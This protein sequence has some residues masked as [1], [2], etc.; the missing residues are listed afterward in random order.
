MNEITLN[1]IVYVPKAEIE[2][3]IK[4]IKTPDEGEERHGLWINFYGEAYG[5]AKCSV[6]GNDFDAIQPSDYNS[7]EWWNI[8]CETYRYCP[9][10]GTRM[11]G[12][13]ND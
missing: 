5:V 1:G 3:A 2:E 8:F 10:C 12:E 7:S 6:C 9:C 4:A 13:E 11:D